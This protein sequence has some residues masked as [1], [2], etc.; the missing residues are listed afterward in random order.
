MGTWL[1][2]PRFGYFKAL[3][4]LADPCT[5]QAPGHAAHVA[6]VVALAV[7]AALLRPVTHAQ[8]ELLK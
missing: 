2:D 5:A 4:D 3:P 6:E 1:L 8:Q 7:D